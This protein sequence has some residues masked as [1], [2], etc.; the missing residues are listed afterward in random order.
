MTDGPKILRFPMALASK[1]QSFSLIVVVAVALG[2]QSVSAPVQAKSVAQTFGAYSAGS[3]KTVDHAPWTALLSKYV[4][5]GGDGLNRVNYAKFKSEGH[6]QLKAYVASLERADVSALDRPEQFAFWANLYNA[7]TIDIVLDHYPVKSIKDIS[8][9]GSLTALVTGGPWKAD[10]VKVAG[11]ALSL[12]DIEHGI[13]RPVFKDPRVHYAVNCASIGCP[14]LLPKAF[15]GAE[16]ETQLDG[17]AKAYINNA[18]GIRV[19]NGTVTAS[20]IYKWFQE[21]FGGNSAG[22]LQHVRTYANEDLK[23]ALKGI[24]TISRFDYDWGLNDAKQ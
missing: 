18:R 24:T 1:W 22:V 13:L 2:V 19:L 14:N 17:A 4:V 23:A 8:L 10:V 9:G 21:D 6:A 20:S 7:K 3:A 11:K 16:L 5:P 15:T 12:D